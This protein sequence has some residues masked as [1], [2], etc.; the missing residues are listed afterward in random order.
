V[1][2]MVEFGLTMT[3]EKSLMSFWKANQA[4]LDDLKS[5]H[6]DLFERVRSVFTEMKAKLKE[7]SNG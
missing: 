3:S 7:G 2:G 6:P 1:D 4:K 5:N